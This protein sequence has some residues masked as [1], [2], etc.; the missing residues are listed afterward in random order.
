R[1]GSNP[2][3]DW[4]TT[5]STYDIQGNLL[6]VTDALGRIAF[7]HVY[8]LAR[9]ALRSEQLD[10]G[11]RRVVMDAATNIIEQRDS[12]GALILRVYDE[13]NRRVRVWARDGAGEAI[14]LRERLIYGDCPDAGLNP[15]Q[16]IA[17]NLRAKLYRHYDEAGLL[18]FESYDFKGNV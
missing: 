1:N 6:T 11:L 8:D 3:N 5:R 9:H 4:Y 16:A 10:A 7:K 17:L 13:L 18:T 14:T 15:V 12:K 2:A